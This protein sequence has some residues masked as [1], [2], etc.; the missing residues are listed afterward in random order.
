LT[1]SS[2]QDSMT[3]L[4]CSFLSSHSVVVM[5]EIQ[6]YLFRKQFLFLQRI[7]ITEDVLCCHKNASFLAE[8][9]L[10]HLQ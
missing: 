2:V 5:A 3:S 7:W 6:E 8:S 1:E 9:F 10:L 4:T